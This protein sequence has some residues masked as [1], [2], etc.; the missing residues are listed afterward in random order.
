MAEEEEEE[1]EEEAKAKLQYR[2]LKNAGQGVI[3]GAIK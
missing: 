3:K 2:N 1:E